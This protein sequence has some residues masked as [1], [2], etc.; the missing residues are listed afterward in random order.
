MPSAHRVICFLSAF[1]LLATSAVALK[2]DEDDEKDDKADDLFNNL[3]SDIKEFLAPFADR[4][5]MQF[6]S[7]SFTT[8]DYIL[9]AVKCVG[10]LT[11]IVSAIRAGGPQWLRSMIGRATENTAVVEQ[12]VM[13][14]TSKDVCELY[15]GTAVV[16][17]PGQAPVY[18]FILLTYGDDVP[19]TTKTR[20][21]SMKEI[22]EQGYM[23]KGSSSAL[24]SV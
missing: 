10:P 17:C 5:T 16:R 13:S 22:V 14:S 3:A 11:T 8:S 9:A 19:Q 18:E 23:I 15:N 24:Q 6:L 1:L 21:K 20:E 7:Q 4:F 2:K 12:D